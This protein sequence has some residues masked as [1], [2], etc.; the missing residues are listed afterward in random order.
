MPT[1]KTVYLHNSTSFPIT[2]GSF[3][4][5]RP[6]IKITKEAPFDPYSGNNLGLFSFTAPINSSENICAPDYSMVSVILSNL[7][8]HDYDGSKDSIGIRWEIIDPYQTKYTGYIPLQTETLASVMSDTFELMSALPIMYAGTYE[9]KAWLENLFDDIL[10]DDTITY[11]YSSGRIGLPIDDD[12]SNS[13]LSSTFIS[14]PIVGTDVWETYSDPSSPVQPDFGTGMLR[15]V[16]EH[17]TISQLSIRQLDLNGSINPKLEFW[18]YHDITAPVMDRSYTDVNIMADGILTRVLSVFRKDT[19]N[20]WKQYTIDLTPYTGNECVLVEF[21]STNRFGATSIQ[22]IDRIAISSMP[23]LAVSKIVISPEIS[24]CN[25]ANKDLSVVLSTVVNQRID[26]S[27]SGD[28]LAVEVPG[29]ATFKVPLQGSVL[30]NN[31]ITVPVGNINIPPD[32]NIIKAYLT[33][34]VDN[35]PSNDTMYYILDIRPELSITI[36]SMTAGENC[37]KIGNN[38]QQE[39]SLKNTGNMDIANISLTLQIDTGETGSIAY[40]IF[41]EIYTDTIHVGDSIPNY[42]FSSIYKAPASAIYYVRITAYLICDSLL[43]N[44]VTATTECADI[45]DISIIQLNNPNAQ[46]DV[47]GSSENVTVSIANTSDVRSY[48]NV[49]ILLFIEDE[50]GV[51]LSSRFETISEIEPSSVQPFTFAE[52][53][54]IPDIPTYYIRVYLNG[55]DNYPENDS[56]LVQRTTN[57]VSVN[58]MEKAG[59]FS[60]EQNIPNPANKST[61]IN[62][63]IPEAGEVVFHLHSISGQLLYSETIETISGKHNLELNTSRLSSGIYFY[64]IEYK[65]QRLIKRMMINN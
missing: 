45:H 42:R 37:F 64:S 13:V 26:F 16:G 57:T 30:G 4:A 11:L 33:S 17:G 48:S 12:F 58:A 23:D 22:Y 50:D 34:P 29:Y 56:L 59:S 5:F 40:A 7:G 53:Y 6:N 27:A 65:G 31:S 32:S 47:V 15:Y 63:S 20:G 10:Y 55:V 60:I 44:D 39:I 52:A 61:R 8:T 38:V 51:V 28:S 1:V 9:I 41:N 19:I 25:L 3:P 2:G 49:S 62:Y 46:M 54:I 43:V 36:N 35:Y 24:V 18:Y 14:T 21:M